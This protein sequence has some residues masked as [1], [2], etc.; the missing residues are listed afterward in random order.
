MKINTL[1]RYSTSNL[2][3][4]RQIQPLEIDEKDF[5]R[6]TEYHRTVAYLVKCHSELLNSSIFEQRLEELEAR[7]KEINSEQA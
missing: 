6:L 3:S 5:K 7:I 1:V 2:S 4:Y